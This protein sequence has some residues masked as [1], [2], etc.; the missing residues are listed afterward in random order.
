MELRRSW[1]IFK[2]R[3]WIPLV[4]VIGTALT[5]GALSFLTKPTYVAAATVQA[6]VTTN[7]NT[8]APTQTLS[9]QE[10]VSSNTLALAVIK[11]LNLNMSPVD[12]TQ[13]IRVTAGHSD[14]FTISIT[15]PDPNEAVAI[16]NSV[17]KESVLIYQT[18]NAV[19]DTTVFDNNVVEQRK[20][21]L[22]RFDEAE[23]ALLQFQADHP[24][25]LQQT[26]DIDL[27]TKYQEL[28]LDQLATGAAY[29]AFQQQTTTSLVNAIS[30]ATHFSA[31]VLDTAIAKPD[32]SSRYTKVAYAAALALVLGVGLIFLLEYMDNS[33]R[34][35]ES[36][37]EMIGAPVVGIIPKATSQTLRSSTGGAT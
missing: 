8:L 15:D 25:I 35:P 12:L 16:A 19:A 20:A 34:E 36:V 10:V 22:K 18:K 1:R 9:F 30:E 24:K 27:Q 4:L 11:D 7:G 14:L 37:E 13:L 32:L 5:V 29:S 6:K 17:A 28:I 23:Q 2:R 33:I 31:S 26:S 3:A 21:F